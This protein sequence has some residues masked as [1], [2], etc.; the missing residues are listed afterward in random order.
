M[1]DKSAGN[2]IAFVGLQKHHTNKVFICVYLHPKGICR[3]TQARSFAAK[4]F[5]LNALLWPAAVILTGVDK[6]AN[7][8]RGS[9]D[10]QHKNVFCN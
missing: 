2:A 10:K 5:L 3:F 8:Q 4:Q 7:S 6:T 1:S 9:S